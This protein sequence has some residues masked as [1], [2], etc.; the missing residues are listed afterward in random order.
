MIMMI[1]AKLL[2]GDPRVILPKA[3]VCNGQR[4]RAN[5]HQFAAASVEA[6]KL[7]DSPRVRVLDGDSRAFADTTMA[8]HE[9]HELHEG[10]P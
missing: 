6:G 4:V 7:Y 10:L 9:V 1:S 3:G 2:G 8:N 5:V